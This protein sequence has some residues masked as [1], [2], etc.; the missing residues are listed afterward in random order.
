[1]W[2]TDDDQA[3]KNSLCRAISGGPIYVSDKI[4]RT[5][6]EILKPL[7][8]EDGRIIRPDESATPTADCLMHNPTTIEKIFK[9]RNRIGDKGV[10]AVFNINAENKPVSGTLSPSE[11]GIS[12]GRYAYYEYFTRERGVLEKGDCINISLNDNDEYR[13]YSFIPYS[14]KIDF[15]RTDKFMGTVMIK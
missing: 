12:E 15:G 4:G 8:F 13:L 1:M 11:L 6:P 10:C 5:N 7:C 3:V 14:E 2:W 9:I